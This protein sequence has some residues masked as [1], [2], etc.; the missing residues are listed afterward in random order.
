[1]L[2]AGLGKTIWGGIQEAR[3]KALQNRNQ[4]PVYDIPGG[5]YQNEGMFQ[6]LS[7]EGLPA[8]DL[9]SMHEMALRG[10]SQSLSAGTQ[11]GASPNSV[12][13]YYQSYL[14][15]MQEIGLKNSM[16]RFTNINALAGSREAL[17]NQEFIKFGYNQDAPY[18]DR[19]QLAT[20]E[21]TEGVQNISGGIDMGIAAEAGQESR[22]LYRQQIKNNTVSVSGGPASYTGGHMTNS[23]GQREMW[24]SQVPGE[25]DSWA[26]QFQ[27]ES[28][29]RAAARKAVEIGVP[30]APNENG[31]YWRRLANSWYMAPGENK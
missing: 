4:R 24:G 19:A 5:Y 22:D 2:T 3:G 16:Q 15:N 31:Y 12:N 7:Q 28:D 23:V 20:Q 9:Q 11:L 10:L 18:K 13:D 30:S 29:T 14:N 1:M 25:F 6:Q 21:Q 8:S 17:A 26:R 27:I